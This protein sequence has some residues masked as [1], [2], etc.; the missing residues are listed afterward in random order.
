MRETPRAI[1]GCFFAE[2]KSG[3]NMEKERIAEVIVDIAHSDV[4]KI[5]DYACD[6]EVEPG[7]RVAVPFGLGKG[8]TTGFVIRLKKY[9]ARSIGFPP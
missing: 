2:R 8:T 6:F 3:G 4:D 1:R 5:F 9:T 7:T